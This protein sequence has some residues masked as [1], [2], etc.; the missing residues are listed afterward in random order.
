MEDGSSSSNNKYDPNAVIAAANGA[1]DLDGGRFIFQSALLEWVDDAREGGGQQGES[2]GGTTLREAVATLW[3]AYAR[4]LVRHK[5]F[6]SAGDAYEEAARCPVAGS[7]GRVHAERARF[8]AERNKR[9]TAQD[10][11][12]RGLGAVADEQDRELLWSDFLDMMRAA[13]PGLTLEALRRAVEQETTTGTPPDA[14]P[15]DGDD[16][17]PDAKRQKQ[18]DGKAAAALESAAASK[19]HVVTSDGVERAARRLAA[20]TLRPVDS[21]E[22]PP[23]EIAAAWMSRDGNHPPQ[24]PEHALFAPSPPKLSDPV[25]LVHVYF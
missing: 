4:Y 10:A 22:L 9:R 1:P 6:R 24:P 7:V 12:L 21:K 20:E 13:N 15:S 23:P 16:E 25:R 8:A 2:D 14:E 5:Q 11:Y 19:T 18:D 17:P 3:L